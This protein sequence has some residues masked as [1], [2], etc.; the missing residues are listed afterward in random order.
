MKTVLS[1]RGYGIELSCFND[2]QLQSLKDELT[3]KPNIMDDYNEGVE[4]FPVYRL[5]EKRIYVPKFYGIQKYGKPLKIKEHEGAGIDV[6]FNGSLKDHQIQFCNKMLKEINEKGSCIASLGTGAGKTV[7]ALWTICQLKKRTM[8]IVHKNFLLEQWI[9]RIKQFIPDATVGIIRQ[10][11]FDIDCDIVIAMIQT[12]IS[13]DF[14]QNTFKD[15]QNVIYD[16]VHHMA[17]KSF[18][19]ILFKCKSKYSLGLSATVKRKDGLTKVLNWSL[20]ETITNTMSSDVETPMVKFIEADYRSNIV[21]KTNFKG[22]LNLPDL[23]NKLTYD[24]KRN[25]QII[26]EIVLQAQQGRKILALSGRREHCV[27][28]NDLLESRNESL[29]NES[30]KDK[31]TTGLYM[32]GMKNEALE[33]S[34]KADVIFATYQSVSEGYD[35]PDLDTLIMCTGMSDVVQTVGRILRRKNKNRPLII[36]VVDTKFLESQARRRKQYYRQKKFT[37]VDNKIVVKDSDSENSEN[38][39]SEDEIKKNE[40]LFE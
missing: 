18:S 34:N 32:G 17:A 9:E 35:N 10:K 31:I 24:D 3:V 1:N 21:T 2:E 12:L 15:I 38:S 30:L 14:E 27:H 29:K 6:N 4:P 16:E 26:D 36:D 33:K 20:G 11:E 40:C 23:I 7:C 25:E 8:V 22:K 37:I 19:Q 28:L 13:R 39:E 5:S